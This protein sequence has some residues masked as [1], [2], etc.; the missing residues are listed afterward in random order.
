M[1]KTR[2]FRI[3]KGLGLTQTQIS[4]LLGTAQGNYAQVELGKRAISTKF[5]DAL[6]ERLGVNVSWLKGQQE[7]DDDDSHMFNKEQP[8]ASDRLKRIIMAAGLNELTL[9][10]ALSAEDREYYKQVMDNCQWPSRDFL[11][12]LFKE[13]PAIDI[14]YVQRGKSLMNVRKY[15]EVEDR[16]GLV[17]A[18]DIMQA[19][20]RITEYQQSRIET[21]EKEL[22]DLKKQLSKHKE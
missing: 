17:H 1:K 3:R 7:D 11:E 22:E 21:L 16:D 13:Y 20:K 6:I 18:K 14:D 10:E 2:L 5:Q 19:Y 8:L 4:S 12:R 9:Q 15:N